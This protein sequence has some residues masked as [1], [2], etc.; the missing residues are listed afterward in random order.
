MRLARRFRWAFLA[1][2]GL[3][4]VDAGTTLVGPLI[5]RHGLD[6]GVSAQDGKLLWRFRDAK[7]KKTYFAGNTANI[8]QLQATAPVLSLIVDEAIVQDGYMNA[9]TDGYGGAA[10]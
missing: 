7:G 4:L 6:F 8:P 1:V 2:A 9:L 10:S 3:V 5:I